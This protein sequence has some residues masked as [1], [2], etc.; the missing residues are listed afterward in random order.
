MSSGTQYEKAIPVLCSQA[1]WQTLGWKPVNGLDYT[2]L[3]STSEI[4]TQWGFG[5]RP[6]KFLLISPR[7]VSGWTVE[8]RS[9]AY[10]AARSG[11]AQRS[12]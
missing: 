2:P 5:E 7:E 3:Q 1:L 4:T 10:Y 8:M 9:A 12:E 6:A 11:P